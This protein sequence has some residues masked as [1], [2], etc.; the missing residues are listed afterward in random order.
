MPERLIRIH[1]FLSKT[2]PSALHRR[3]SYTVALMVS[4]VLLR[5]TI[6]WHFFSQGAVKLK[7]PDFRSAYFLD[8]AVGPWSGYFHRLIPDA[9]GVERLDQDAHQSALARMHEHVLERIGDDAEKQ[10]LA[11]EILTVQRQALEYFF[12]Q[13]AAEIEQHKRE[14]QRYEQASRDPNIADIDS[15]QAWLVAKRN[16]L[17]YAAQPWLADLA[18]INAAYRRAVTEQLELTGAAIPMAHDPGAKSWVDRTVSWTI[19]LTGVCLLLGLF[20]APAALVGGAFLLSVMSTQPFWVSGANLLYLPYQLVELAG[21][22][23]LAVSGAG[24]IAGLDF[25]LTA[26][27]RRSPTVEQRT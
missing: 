18:S 4:L 21:L 14:V 2:M 5:F 6:G 23:L 15:G 20:T 26:C 27:W 22:L 10:T 25:F 1:R 13:H 24:Q 9:F 11:N 19:F 17:R 12:A 16:E 3:P 8:L 7:D